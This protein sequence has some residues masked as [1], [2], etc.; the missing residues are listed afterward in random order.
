MAYSYQHVASFIDITT[1]MQRFIFFKMLIKPLGKRSALEVKLYD[2]MLT[3][4]HKTRPQWV[5]AG[6][7][8]P[9]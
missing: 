6:A 5:E 9:K 2:R 4:Q 8:S 7:K 3:A 1:T